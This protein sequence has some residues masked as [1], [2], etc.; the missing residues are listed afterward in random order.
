MKVLKK[1]TAFLLAA[2]LLF[3]MIPANASAAE[4]PSYEISGPDT[5]EIRGVSEN[6]RYAVLVLDISGSMSG[7]PL[8]AQKAAA[9]KFCEAL[10]AADGSNYAAVVSFGSSV[11]VTSEF[12]SDIEALKTA[13]N[14]IRASNSTNTVGALTK[15]DEL[16][17]QIPE[18][19]GRSIVLCTDGLPNMGTSSTS[20][21]FTSS[22]SSSYYR[23]ANGVYAKAFELM[24]KYDV[25]TLGFFHSLSGNELN[26]AR[27]FLPAIQN[28]GYYEVTDPEDLE[29]TFGDIADDVVSPG[30][31]G[32]F[33]VNVVKGNYVIH[34]VDE[35][36]K[37]LRGVTVTCNDASATTDNNGLVRFKKEL[38][39][40][41]PK[42]TATAAGYQTWTNEESNW[43]MPSSGY[44]TIKMY[45]LTGSQG[46]SGD[47][48]GSGSGGASVVD[49]K[50]REC[51]YSN[52]ADMSGSVNL[53][54]RTK[55]VSLG[56]DLPVAGDLDFGDFYI[57]CRANTTDGIVRYE[58]WQGVTKIAE[59]TDGNFGKLSVDRH[60]FAEGGKCR[61]RVVT[62]T[63]REIDTSIN[64]QFKKHPINEVSSISF[65]GGG[66]AG[67]DSKISVKVGD[68]V[69]FIGGSTFTAK[70][71]IS[72]PVTVLFDDEKIQI[73]FNLTDITNPLEDPE[74]PNKTHEELVKDAKKKQLEE[75][76]KFLTDT[77]T[78]Q[79]L[80]LGKLS[81]SQ[82][83][84]FKKLIKEG[85]KFK[86]FK[87]G[88]L[89]FLCYVEGNW[90]DSTLKGHAAFQG[91]IDLVQFGYSTWVVVVPVTIQVKLSLEGNL[92]G[93][94]GYDWAN[95]QLIGS[96]DFDA[97]AELEAFGG[98]G[99]DKYVG[100]GAYGSAKL[101]GKLRI[102]GSPWGVRNVDLTGSL[103]AKAYL[104]WLEWKRAFAQNTWHIYTGNTVRS[105]SNTA[106]NALSIYSIYDADGYETQNLNYL[107]QE[108]GW[109]GAAVMAI[110]NVAATQLQK[111]VENT[112]RNAQPTMI[113]ANDTLYAAFLKADQNTGSVSVMMT[114]Y[115]GGS[116][117]EP[118]SVGS[119]VMDGTPMLCTDGTKI[120]LAYTS[121]EA[122]TD[123]ADLLAY[124]KHQSLVVGT[125]DAETLKFTTG[126]TYTGTGYVNIPQL[127]VLNGVP[128]V[129]WADS[130]VTDADSVLW[131][132][133]S[134]IY[135]ASLT[136]ES[137]DE[138][139][140]AAQV[141]KPVTQIVI[142]ARDGS[143]V[144]AY[145]ADEDGDYRP[146]ETENDEGD[147][148]AVDDKS[149][150]ISGTGTAAATNVNGVVKYGTIPGQDAADFMWNDDGCLKTVTHGEVPAE[151]IT[152]MY[153][154]AGDRVYYSAADGD[155][156]HLTAVIRSGSGWSAPVTF[157]GGDGYLENI[158]VVRANGTDYVMG[159][160]TDVTISADTVDD[161]KS[162]V[163]GS[164]KPVNDLKLDGVAYEADGLAAGE[165][166][167]MTLSVAN[168]GDHEINSL[169]VTYGA[170]STTIGDLHISAGSE[171]EVKVT[172]Q[173]PS[174]V[175]EYT[176]TVNE[177]GKVDYTPDDNSYTVGLGYPDIAVELEEERIEGN[178]AIVA[179]IYNYGVA[180]ASG[181]VKIYDVSG[182]LVESRTFSDLQSG[183]SL[184]LN[185][186][187]EN[188]G[189]YTVTAELSG[190][191][192]D[193][194]A[195]NNSA[196]I[197]VGEPFAVVAFDPNGGTGSM[198]PVQADAAG[199]CVLPACAFTAPSGMKFSK[200]EIDGVT[201]SAGDKI[202]IKTDTVAKA[203]WT[204]Q[205]GE[206]GGG[207]WAPLPSASVKI[208]S[209]DNGYFAVSDM[210]ATAGNTVQIFPRANEGYEVDQVTAVDKNGKPVAVKGNGD[211][212]YSFVMPEKTAHPVTV[213]VTF[214]ELH[215]CPSE[216]FTDVDQSAWYHEG[217][218]YAIRN[219]LM[220]GT[221]GT[222]FAPDSTT[223]RAML[224]T[225]LYR[226]EGEPGVAT[227]DFIDVKA[228]QWYTD[229]VA[230]ASA[231]K[232]VEGYGNGTFGPEDPITREQMAVIL[233][234]YAGYKGYDI[235]GRDDLSDFTDT[236]D[237]SGWAL[238][239]MRWAVAKG[240]LEGTSAAT[241]TPV[242]NS[243]RAQMATILM[244]FC[245]R[246][247]K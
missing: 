19:A 169:V 137:W 147:L 72:S 136:G 21:P 121:T 26:F 130:E 233:Y 52:S 216:K 115:S 217:V 133:S 85:N 47:G 196:S 9:I 16:L 165:D 124:A 240:L 91:K 140:Q 66:Q 205:S 229:A 224:V 190:G 45:S 67:E 86:F 230:W 58:L 145:V 80:K 32:I 84:T 195:Y 234:R 220:N 161:E 44:T 120:Y 192:D 173:C 223:T 186:P 158:S 200:W 142:G 215:N 167:E 76:K 108:S 5:Q 162:L 62:D 3:A 247:Q 59:S 135:Y 182:K 15:A 214:K 245:D 174:E 207:S 90:S 8:T 7:R 187:V 36:G 81:K 23:Y 208:E 235:T 29:F 75:A 105:V 148:V 87:D 35:K 228:G 100:V 102:I 96:V 2:C 181:T 119:G 92:I 146:V 155:S 69:P 38:F 198:A 24:E 56:N 18:S 244:R 54:T 154:I 179:H 213:K 152:G 221:G 132:M 177:I 150:Y 180:A 57:T 241:L 113:A 166:V 82:E 149:L 204:E 242:G 4:A 168:A 129:A 103:G 14:G 143:T 193:L 164:V 243:T 109:N 114:K 211:G 139:V 98:I 131:P 110:D 40:N 41:T 212:T 231:N 78:A 178:S 88:E 53:L 34:V 65:T 101:E 191:A 117:S 194:Y 128:T 42:I 43:E 238:A 160:L 156:A 203:I 189:L 201:Y 74:H 157:T 171:A 138:A 111:L 13:I 134:T 50:L 25:F 227:S 239:S 232:I 219:G 144:V 206:G 31:S 39:K 209:A 125:V 104:G 172:V 73:G 22:D 99:V 71:P 197:H 48:G 37:S 49:Y 222:T 141:D 93:E 199:E 237:I 202:T 64:L 1:I 6:V 184:I 27:K 246:I 83:K 61:V 46:G 55:T 28:K 118:V 175:T 97:S 20:G 51:S 68:D 210:Y 163:W 11:R 63:G 122:G 183:D 79:N 70:L 218:D 188:I 116:W 225:I 112:Y 126:R 12:T 176:F 30:H 236:G 226:L 127:A 89:N 170:V 106:A 95:A 33:F 151:G 77:K 123:T 159:I 153:A 17:S 94:I 185:Y 60:P 107:A 10:L